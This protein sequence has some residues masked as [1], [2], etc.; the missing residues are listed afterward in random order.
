[1]ETF[2]TEFK[3]RVLDH[4]ENNDQIENLQSQELGKV[5]EL[6]LLREE[7]LAEKNHALKEATVQLEKLRSEVTR[8]RRQEEQLS[9]VQVKSCVKLM[10]RLMFI[11]RVLIRLSANH[12]FYIICIYGYHFFSLCFTQS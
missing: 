9:D 6:V 2:F 4:Q 11:M 5:K 8:L 12:S 10:S 7:E 1:M 3:Q